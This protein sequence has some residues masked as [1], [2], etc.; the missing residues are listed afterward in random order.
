MSQ[1][2]GELKGSILKFLYGAAFQNSDQL[3]DL[4]NRSQQSHQLAP[5]NPG[6][7]ASVQQG[8]NNNINKY[9]G[10]VFFEEY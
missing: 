1:K 6:S 7:P 10:I 4:V 8:I 3:R 5:E 2:F 9:W